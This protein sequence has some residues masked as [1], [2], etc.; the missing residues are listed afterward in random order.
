[1]TTQML[2]LKEDNFVP[3]NVKTLIVSHQGDL[4]HLGG[5]VA[6]QKD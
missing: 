4:K 6:E 1:M 3:H 5:G 2:N